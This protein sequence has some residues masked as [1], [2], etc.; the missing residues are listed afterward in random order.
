[1]RIELHHTEGCEGYQ[2][3]LHRLQAAIAEERLPV[4]VDVVQTAG[5]SDPSPNIRIFDR[6]SLTLD[7]A[8]AGPQTVDALQD[9]LRA[10][11]NQLTS[12]RFL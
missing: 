11:W 7:V 12:P 5:E 8:A 3:L 9:M 2:R 1:M 10:Q 4:T 6:E